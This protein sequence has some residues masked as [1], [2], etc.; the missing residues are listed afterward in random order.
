MAGEHAIEF[1]GGAE[2]VTTSRMI[3]EGEK[4]SF[5]SLLSALPPSLPSC[6]LLSAYIPF[7]PIMSSSML[8]LLLLLTSLSIRKFPASA[9]SRH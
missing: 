1:T 4:S 2:A 8:Y 9:I 6:L 3:D 5:S 7:P